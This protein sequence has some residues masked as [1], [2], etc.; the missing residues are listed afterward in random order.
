M[1]YGNVQVGY[2]PASQAYVTVSQENGGHTSASRIA[3]HAPV[4]VE[5]E[6][7]PVT[8]VYR[9]LLLKNLDPRTGDHEVKKV[10][11]KLPKCPD[12]HLQVNRP[13]AA[14]TKISA[15]VTLQTRDAADH[16][17]HQ[18]QKKQVTIRKRPISL[19]FGKPIEPAGY[20]ASKTTGPMVVSSS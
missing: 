11:D 20:L 19:E 13:P 7:E 8:L 9:V 1:P 3:S 14:K 2:P 4:P 18:W 5:P 15:V 16:M 6:F 17:L 12:Y 10:L